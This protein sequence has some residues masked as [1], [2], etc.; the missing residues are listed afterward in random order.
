MNLMVCFFHS[1]IGYRRVVDVF[2]LTHDASTIYFFSGRI[3]GQVVT[4]RQS[5]LILDSN[6]PKFEARIDL[7]L[8]DHIPSLRY[9]NSVKSLVDTFTSL[10]MVGDI[11][12]TVRPVHAGAKLVAISLGKDDTL[13]SGTVAPIIFDLNSKFQAVVTVRSDVEVIA[14]LDGESYYLPSR[15]RIGC[16]PKLIHLWCDK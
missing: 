3:L 4:H 1:L 10:N 13:S 7:C 5:T 14:E 6:R 16:L 2:T 8:K 11:H 9:Q 15:F 12:G